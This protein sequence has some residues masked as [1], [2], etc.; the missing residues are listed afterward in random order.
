MITYI[1][2]GYVCKPQIT[3]LLRDAKYFLM[4]N[5]RKQEL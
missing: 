4:V 1:T 5:K 3:L 2:P